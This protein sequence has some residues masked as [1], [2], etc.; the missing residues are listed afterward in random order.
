V[1]VGGLVTFSAFASHHTHSVWTH[2]SQGQI[3]NGWPSPPIQEHFSGLVFESYAEGAVLPRRS[4]QIAHTCTETTSAGLNV[5]NGIS[6]S[7]I[8]SNW[9]M[10]YRQTQESYSGTLGEHPL[11]YP[12]LGKPVTALCAV[13]LLTPVSAL[14]SDQERPCARRTPILEAS[15]IIRGLPRRLPLAR[16]FRSPARTRS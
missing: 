5:V 6:V 2:S 9:R 11:C 14:I 3:I 8:S 13:P 16:A 10:P 7:S 1:L 15:T 4:L 12:I